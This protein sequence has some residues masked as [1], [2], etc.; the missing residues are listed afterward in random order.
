M[1]H[2]LL[3]VAHLSDRRHVT[4][5]CHFF[6]GFLVAKLPDF[7]ACTRRAHAIGLVLEEEFFRMGC[8]MKRYKETLDN[9]IDD[10]VDT[11]AVDDDIDALF[12]ILDEQSPDHEV[13]LADD[14]SDKL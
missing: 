4:C 9:W 14:D 7:C 12:D 8:A 10:F 11:Y 1:R 6:C 3:A 2:T 13:I 5:F